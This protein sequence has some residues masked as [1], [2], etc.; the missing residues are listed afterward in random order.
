M[1]INVHSHI[2]LPE[3]VELL[4]RRRKPPRVVNQGGVDRL[5]IVPGEG[6]SGGVPGRPMDPSYWSVTH[7]LEYMARHEI[8]VTVLSLGNPWLDFL[9][10]QAAPVWAGRLNRALARLCEDHPGRLYGLG[11]LPLQRPETAAS[12][13]GHLAGLPGI[14]GAIIGTRGAGQ[15]LDD[16]ALDPVWARAE[17]LDLALFVHP[18]YGIGTD[19]L[20]PQAYALNF[21][22]GFL[23]ETTIAVARLI[24]S[25]VPDRFP[26]LRL[27]IAHG[28]GTLPYLVGRLDNGARAYVPGLKRLP[29]EDLRRL[30]YD[31]TVYHAPAVTC[32]LESVGSDRLMFG[33][34]HPFRKDPSDVYRSLAG[35]APADREAILN[36]TASAFFRL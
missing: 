33:T 13:L 14:R 2:Y 19:L 28:G 16:P 32:A 30:S 35:L 36:R 20:G 11:V 1:P 25:G 6:A 5:V 7:T 17:A 4:R 9:D 23:F 8:D 12:E 31:V 24:L 21:A 26:R 22:L 18:H 15:G 10:P 34:D 3:Y 27:L 29:S